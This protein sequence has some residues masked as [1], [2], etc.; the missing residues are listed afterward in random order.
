[1]IRLK[2]AGVDLSA[3]AFLSGV[4]VETLRRMRDHDPCHFTALPGVQ[5]GWSL[6]RYE[7][8]VAA[9]RQPLRYSSAAGGTTIQD[10]TPEEIAY[11]R[12]MLHV[13]PPEHTALRR[14]FQG[15][16]KPEALLALGPVFDQLALDL[17]RPQL[18]QPTEVVG[19]L[20]APM[21]AYSLCEALGVPQ[22]L[23]DYFM[24]LSYLMLADTTPDP[25]AIHYQQLAL[26][27]T[28]RQAFG[29]SPSRAMMQLLRI[30]GDERNHLVPDATP[31][32]PSVAEIEDLLVIL[33]TAGTGMTQNCIVMGLR[34]L[35]DHWPMISRE[36]EF[37]LENLTPL[38]EEVIRIACPLYHVRRTVTEEHEMH[39]KTLHPG[40]KVV[41]WLYS[42][43]LDDRIYKDPE[44]FD[45]ART[46]NPH[47]SFGRG[48]PHYC[49]GA[50]LAR[51]EV[52]SI[53]KAI[54]QEA[55]SID[56]IG[57]PEMLRSNFV[58]ETGRLM[59][60]IEGIS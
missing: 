6:V 51:M 31:N 42:G 35:A 21:V 43:N 38:V 9:L 44:T 40:D 52:A 24:R 25:A 60:R 15:R 56:V 49:L 22:G 58:R 28:L 54:L 41:L 3:D 1:M 7:D 34:L 23:R 45:P 33:A 55:A 30:T 13:D 48:S 46:P 17:V 20:A 47:L 37:F 27:P 39:G 19:R 59:L 16:F 2:A 57:K 5:P 18:G 11:N 32:G 26:P 29:G 14:M 4:A 36:R 50:A 8:I 53:F 10:Q 12:S